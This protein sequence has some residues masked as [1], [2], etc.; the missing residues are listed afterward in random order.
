MSAVWRPT[1]DQFRCGPWPTQPGCFAKLDSCGFYL[2]AKL[3]GD[4]ITLA[5]PYPT[6]AV[7]PGRCLF[8][9]SFAGTTGVL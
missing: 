3:L 9:G 8:A 1:T 7:A 2:D 5:D 6:V 4:G